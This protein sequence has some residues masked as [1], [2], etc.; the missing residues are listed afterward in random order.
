MMVFK[1]MHKGYT[2]PE[3]DHWRL[4][5]LGMLLNQCREMVTCYEEVEEITGLID[6]L[7]SS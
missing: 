4:P 5:L 6:S 3:V 7:C 1:K 2:V